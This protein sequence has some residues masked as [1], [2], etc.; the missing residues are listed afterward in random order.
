MQRLQKPWNRPKL[1]EAMEY[2][3]I[4]EAM[5]FAGIRETME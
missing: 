4:A 2:A 1:A 3:G 5:K